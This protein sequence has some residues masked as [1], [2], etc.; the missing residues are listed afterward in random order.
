MDEPISFAVDDGTQAG[1]YAMREIIDSVRSGRRATNTLVWWAGQPD[2]VAFDAVPGLLAELELG[3]QPPPPT[4][5]ESA[6]DDAAVDVD[7]AAVGVDAKA[8][9][10]SVLDPSNPFADVAEYSF[11]EEALAGDA[12]DAVETSSDF[13]FDEQ[14]DSDVP[15]PS[16]PYAE[17]SLMATEEPDP[18]TT[19]GWGVATDDVADASEV[20]DDWREFPGQAADDATETTA[21]GDNLDVSSDF[22]VDSADFVDTQFGSVE[23][24][25]PTGFGGSGLFG[26]G[27]SDESIS[28]P[29]SLQ[30]VSERIEALGNEAPAA[31]A[32]G[33]FGS[34]RRIIQDAAVEEQIAADEARGTEDE[35]AAEA[36]QEDD[37]DELEQIVDE[38]DQPAEPEFDASA[39][40]E[41]VTSFD[42][43]AADPELD[44]LFETMVADSRSRHQRLDW[45]SKLDDVALGAVIASSLADGYALI[46]LHA[47][48][49]SHQARFEHPKSHERLIIEIDSM[50][51]ASSGG[52]LLGQHAY[53]T[54]G[55]G[56]PV[57]GDDMTDDDLVSDQP[58]V[59]LVEIDAETG[60]AYSTVDLIWE[61]NELL[62]VDRSLDTE[63]VM[64]RI[65]A[66]VHALRKH[67]T[68]RFGIG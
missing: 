1:P 28:E 32:G 59:I 26:D 4:A 50:G 55:L 2:W 37:F 39:E 54:V 41:S 14:I 49:Q 45:A 63:A 42:T 68:D 66:S 25:V 58:G 6:V 44:E 9:T 67:W 19:T 5:D 34:T 48:A 47:L 43:P 57:P 64:R 10:A 22:D 27:P 18:T 13:D 46:D 60:Y 23:E 40:M 53:V 30:S 8:A 17:T 56:K 36:V 33:L 51:P 15:E 16:D 12:V 38:V 35:P 3:N 61:F 62:D 7:D 31:A 21:F 52:E 65:T 20:A 29:S 24:E 11:S